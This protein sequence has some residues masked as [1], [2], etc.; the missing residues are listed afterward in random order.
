MANKKAIKT[1]YIE[2]KKKPKVIL[3]LAVQDTVKSKLL[4]SLIV[5]LREADYDYDVAVSMGA[6]LIGSR[7]R[8]VNQAKKLGGTHMLFLDHDMFLMPSPN[9]AG[10]MVDPITRAL[11]HDKD[12]VG[13]PYHFRSLPLKTTSTPLSDM[14]DKK[15]LYRAQGLGTG[16]M[17]IKMSVFDKIEKPWFQFGRNAESELVYGE[18]WF[19]CQ[20]CIKAGIEIWCDGGLNIKHTGDYD[21]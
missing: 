6:D 20:Q 2:E 1:P 19:F 16:F 5:A 10:K 14:S 11:S 3:A 18:D 8:L 12:V 4:L 21:Y 17:L 9:M 13:A 7:T 15:G